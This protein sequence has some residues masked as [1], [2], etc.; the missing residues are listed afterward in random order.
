[1]ALNKANCIIL[2]KRCKYTAWQTSLFTFL[3]FLLDI[4]KVSLIVC[5]EICK[6][7]LRLNECVV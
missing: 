5:S 1:M 6:V 7:L 3:D 2:L 4:G